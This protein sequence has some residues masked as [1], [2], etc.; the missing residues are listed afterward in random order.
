MS[1]IKVRQK[2]SLIGH[3]EKIQRVVKGLGLKKIGDERVHKDNNCTRGMI[4]KVKHLLDYTL[5]PQGE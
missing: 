2:K 4:N 5:L 1:K 3:P